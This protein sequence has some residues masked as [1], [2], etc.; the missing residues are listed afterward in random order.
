MRIAKKVLSFALALS[1]ALGCLTIGAAG[2]KI[3]ISAPFQ[4]L[5]NEFVPEDSD[6]GIL[7]IDADDVTITDAVVINKDIIID[8]GG[9]EIKGPYGCPIFKIAG[10]NVT[11]KNATLNARVGTYSEKTDL[12]FDFLVDMSAPAL[13]IVGG[14]VTLEGVICNGASMRVP[15][16]QTG[17][18]PVGS[19]VELKN[20]AT[21]TA[22]NSVFIGR[23]GINNAVTG[24]VR[25]GAVTFIDGIAAGYIEGI[26]NSSGVVL[27]DNS[28]AYP[29]GDLIA[30]LQRGGVTVTA[31]ERDLLKT[32]VDNRIYFVSDSPE[33]ATQTAC[34][35]GVLTVTVTPDASNVIEKSPVNYTWIPKTVTVNGVTA[36][37]V[38]NAGVYTATFTGIESGKYAISTTQT[39]YIDVT[40]F[41]DFLVNLP[42][43]F[44][45]LLDSGIGF[46]NRYIG[47]VDNAYGQVTDAFYDVAYQFI[48]IPRVYW[49]GT[50]GLADGY[51]KITN[52]VMAIGG[53]QMMNDEQFAAYSGGLINSK[54]VDV[55][56]PAT[57]ILGRFDALYTDLKNNI[58]TPENLAIWAVN[59]YAEL[60]DIVKDLVAEVDNI[61]KV[62][63]T[64]VA[65]VDA[66]NCDL[67]LS[68]LPEIEDY[69]AIVNQYGPYLK[70]VT[71][72]FADV[73]A[74][75]ASETG[76]QIT[77]ALTEADMIMA[78]DK[79][80]NHIDTYYEPTIVDGSLLKFISSSA[81]GTIDVV[82]T[83]IK[84]ATI[85]AT[86]SGQGKVSLENGFSNVSS[87]SQTLQVG[88]KKTITATPN[89]NNKFLY[90]KNAETNKIVSYDAAFEVTVG[91]STQYVAYF[92]PETL[93]KVTFLTAYNSTIMTEDFEERDSD[94]ADYISTA[95]AP[96]ITGYTFTGWESVGTVDN[97]VYRAVYSVVDNDCEVA[98]SNSGASF[99]GA[100][101]YNLYD[102]VTISAPAGG[103]G[104]WENAVTHEKISYFAT[105]SF[106]VTESVEL[107]AVYTTSVAAGVALNITKSTA[108][109]STNTVS[110]YS[111]RS[112][113]GYSLVET[114]MVVTNNAT[115]ALDN[116][117]FVIGGTGVLKAISTSTSK[118]GTFI[119][120]KRNAGTGV[121]WYARAYVII[122][123]A[124]GEVTTVYSAVKS[125]S[126][127]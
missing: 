110:F 117:S 101:T 9:A 21:L 92:A 103:F 48:R 124:N 70:K 45:D 17:Y 42:T 114:G 35:D 25:G 41:N 16:T 52:A 2:Y 76:M 65:W 30:D 57:G 75:L 20:G 34:E 62:L 14:N 116:E 22:D 61:Y 88:L 19:G 109:S 93:I 74:F 80:N 106:I 68:S 98:I 44:T 60:Y 7:H 122:Q 72:A 86:A 33:L 66:L 15:F 23:Y 115:T 119:V 91:S 84:T 90:W 59:N 37:V 64:D 118:A 83:V 63:T 26:K 96:D 112:I 77:G 4:D 104:Y 71:D 50:S 39:M 18:V 127:S 100:G 55:V 108:N 113:K 78:F 87:G 125:D 126:I 31:D 123:D 79:L 40:E 24:S 85:T 69:M 5:I 107:R 54:G 29:A 27:G 11:I 58:D 53:Q 97:E 56:I 47:D 1:L 94:Y 46:I 111:E 120:N 95:A 102:S 49:N 32:L 105:Y 81:S 10:G 89:A 67:L 12:D 28:A 82:D 73:D 6:D 3:V 38:N 43:Y 121:V 99:V 36:D 51:D 13:D 8:F